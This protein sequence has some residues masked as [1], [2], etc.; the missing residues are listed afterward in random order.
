[1]V[2]QAERRTGAGVTAWKGTKPRIQPGAPNSPPFVQQNV[3]YQTYSAGRNQKGSDPES[4]TTSP[5]RDVPRQTRTVVCCIRD[6]VRFSR[7]VVASGSPA[8]RTTGLDMRAG[9]AS[10]PPRRRLEARLETAASGLDRSVA[11]QLASTPRVRERERPAAWIVSRTRGPCARPT[12]TLNADGPGPITE[13]R[14][15]PKRP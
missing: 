13:S 4:V 6:S 12:P 15:T 8:R 5:A 14:E 7:P 9:S 1:M 11:H 10:C 2:V 3:H